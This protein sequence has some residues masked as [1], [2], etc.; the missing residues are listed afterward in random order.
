MRKI[1]RCSESSMVMAMV[2][3]TREAVE[4][5]SCRDVCELIRTAKQRVGEK[6]DIAGISCRKGC[7]RYICTSWFLRL[8]ESTFEKRKSVF[9]FTLQALFVLEIYCSDI[10]MS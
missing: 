7:I 6:K 3:K 9:Y 5:G 1:E 10:Q 2:Q 8:K 4:V